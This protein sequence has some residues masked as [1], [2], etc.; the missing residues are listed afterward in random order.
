MLN[1]ERE[2]KAVFASNTFSSLI[3]TKQ[4]NDTKA[5]FIPFNVFFFVFEFEFRRLFYSQPH[6]KREINANKKRIESS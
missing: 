4:A 3:K 1:S 5:T 2:T 6:R